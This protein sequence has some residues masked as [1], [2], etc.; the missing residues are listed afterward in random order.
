[1]H[2]ALSSADLGGERGMSLSRLI[3]KRSPGFSKR[4]KPSK[5]MGF[6][7]DAQR[8]CSKAAMLSEG[9]S[10]SNVTHTVFLLALWKL[11]LVAT[12]GFATNCG[13]EPLHSIDAARCASRGGPNLI[14]ISHDFPYVHTPIQWV[15][16]CT[17]RLD[18]KSAACLVNAIGV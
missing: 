1:M 12:N 18:A 9:V 17:V 4:A 3:P 6:L 13:L 2:A 16:A 11:R 7:R 15:T 5:L 14:F 8:D 10:N